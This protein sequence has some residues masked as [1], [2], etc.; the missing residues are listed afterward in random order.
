MFDVHKH[1]KKDACN[2]TAILPPGDRTVKYIFSPEAK[3]GN[4][5]LGI[6][7][8]KEIKKYVRSGVKSGPVSNGKTRYLVYGA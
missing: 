5:K 2:I 7:C 1:L 8:K 6:Y 4:K 3:K